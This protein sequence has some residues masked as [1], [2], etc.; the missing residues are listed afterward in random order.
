LDIEVAHCN[1][2]IVWCGGSRALAIF[3]IIAGSSRMSPS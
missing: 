2:N 1:L 3:G